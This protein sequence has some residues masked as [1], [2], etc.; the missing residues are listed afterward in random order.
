M[1]EEAGTGCHGC[2]CPGGSDGIGSP[3]RPGRHRRLAWLHRTW[4]DRQAY[5]WV[6]PFEQDTGCK[7]NIKTAGTSDEMV[8]LMTQGG[9]D[10]V[11]ASGDASLRLIRGG[12]VQPIDVTRV[13]SFA[14]VDEPPASRAPWHSVDGKITARP[15]SGARTCC[16]TTPRRSRTAPESGRWCLRSQDLRDGKRNKGRVQAYD[17]PIYL[18]DG[19]LYLK[20]NKPELGIGDPYVLNEDQYARRPRRPAP[21]SIRSSTATGTTPPSLSRTSPTKALWRPVPGRSRS[22]RSRQRAADRERHP[23]RRRD[24]LGRYHHARRERRSTPTAPTSGWNGR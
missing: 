10:L 3:R 7:V 6:T 19:A 13:P 20:A 12:T 9:F 16:C 17:G 24:G 1:P 23:C 2:R 22:T 5:D 4:R 18:A 11:T 14:N 21:G 8:T 15:T